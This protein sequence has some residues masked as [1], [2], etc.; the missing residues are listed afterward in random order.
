MHFLLRDILLVTIRRFLA[1]LARKE[2]RSSQT[3]VSRRYLVAIV[4]NGGV[5]P[6]VD[7]KHTE[8]LHKGEVHVG[9]KRLFKVKSRPLV[10]RMK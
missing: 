9:L 7:K 5:N 4:A 6:N 2:Y 3:N 10:L 8:S 1:A